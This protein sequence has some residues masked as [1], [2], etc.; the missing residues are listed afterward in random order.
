MVIIQADTRE[1]NVRKHICAL[2]RVGIAPCTETGLG[3]HTSPR[4]K[5][6]RDSSSVVECND[7]NAS[8][9]I[10]DEYQREK[11]LRVGNRIGAKILPAT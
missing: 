6:G 9:T 3:E 5:C 11:D 2:S 7:D 1:P 10:R 8:N 4:E